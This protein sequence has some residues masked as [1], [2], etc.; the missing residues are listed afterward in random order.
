MVEVGL[1]R[2]QEPYRRLIAEMLEF[3]IGKL[4]D[5]LISIVVYDSVAR[6]EARPD[7]DIDILIVADGL[8]A[9]RTERT[10]LFEMV[11][12]RLEGI[13]RSLYDS[14]YF[15]SFSPIM[16]T[17]SKARTISPLYLD[18]VEDAMIV[19]DKDQFFEKVLDRLSKKLQE[20]GAER[21]WVGKKW[22][23]RLKKEYSPGEVIILK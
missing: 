6:H 22:Y 21:V 5:Q 9:T 2:I 10:R 1:N 4:R 20:L 3:F 13:F 18:M 17:S 19:Y 14:G 12:D 16:K 8:P 15:V 23:W 11:E 7:S